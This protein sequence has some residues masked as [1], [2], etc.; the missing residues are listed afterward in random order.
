MRIKTSQLF[1]LLMLLAC[2]QLSIGDESANPDKLQIPDLGGASNTLFSRQQEHLLGRAWLRGFRSQAQIYNDPLL[3]DYLFNLTYKLTS[4]SELKDRRIELVVV[5]NPRLNAF[6]VPGGIIGVHNGLILAAQSEN[7]LASVLAHEIAH[8][9]QRHY[10]RSV[11][12]A[13]SKSLPNLAALLAG[14]AIAATAGGDAGIAAITAAQA[15][16]L[17]SRLR[18][19]RLHETEADR[20][21]LQTLVD[22]G[23][24]PHAV[25][26]MFE[27]MQSQA[28]YAGERYEFLQTHPITEKRISDS[29]SRARSYPKSVQTDNLGYQLMQA[30]VR[31]HFSKTA[32]QAKDYFVAQMKKSRTNTE[33]NRYGLVLALQA[34]GHWQEASKKLKPLI[35]KDA[36]RISYILADTDNLI[37]MGKIAQAL[38]R[39]SDSL[40]L[41]THNNPLTLRYAEVLTLSNQAKAAEK[42]LISHS[43]VY[44]NN[45]QVWYLLAETH[46]LAGNIVGVHRARAE[47][48]LLNGAFGQAR[49]QLGYALPMVVK[50]SVT[51]AKITAKLKEIRNHEQQ[52]KILR[53]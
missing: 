53:G 37:G 23:M 25:P 17:Q 22:S 6:A 51:T 28:R 9:S 12:E 43:K 11:E 49:K 30:R 45:P 18:Y 2:A 40:A 33:S 5:D 4:H 38:D 46:G 16:N 10:A 21:G 20:V 3:E 14:I 48:F 50:D 19:S 41:N 27:R 44:P 34:L 35:E 36:N 24:D 39:L 13:K 32:Q 29:R 31:T 7:E 1:A 42:L 8:L 52:L 26:K 15:A 47:Y